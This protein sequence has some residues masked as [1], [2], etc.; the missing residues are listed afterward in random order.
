M[1]KLSHS[2]DQMEWKRLER[3][4]EKGRRSRPPI[5]IMKVRS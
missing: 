5:A 4:E 3:E 1:N 2:K